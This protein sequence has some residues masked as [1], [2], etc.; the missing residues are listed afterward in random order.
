MTFDSLLSYIMIS[1]YSLLKKDKHN[2][3]FLI[4]V[5]DPAGNT[6]EMV[7]FFS[8]DLSGKAI[9]DEYFNY[10]NPFSNLKNEQTKIRYVLLKEQGAGVLYI[11]DLGGDMVHIS[12][13]EDSYLTTGSHEIKWN[14]RNLNGD[15]M[16]SGVYLGLL[17]MD[18]SIKKIKIVIRN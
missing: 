2:F 14:G 5:S 9:G 12:K 7:L 4:A 11:L 15:L 6:N 8:V 10:P 18:D 1:D 17:K 13:L 16:S 3:D